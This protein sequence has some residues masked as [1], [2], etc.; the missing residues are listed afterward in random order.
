MDSII[1]PNVPIGDNCIIG[2]GSIV[3][4]NVPDNEVWAGVPAH[5]IKTIEDY[6][7]KHTDEFEFTKCFKSMEKKKYL[8]S[9]YKDL[10]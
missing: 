4:K 10:C 7:L 1:M 8:N 6:H 2:C 5:K 9:K 3:T